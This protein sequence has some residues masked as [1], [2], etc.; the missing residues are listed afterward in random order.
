MSVTKGGTMR[1]WER[2]EQFSQKKRIL[3]SGSSMENQIPLMKDTDIVMKLV[4]N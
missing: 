2:D 3:F 4:I 1:S